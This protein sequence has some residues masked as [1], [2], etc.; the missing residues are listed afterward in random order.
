MAEEYS[1]RRPESQTFSVA[2][3]QTLVMSPPSLADFSLAKQDCCPAEAGAGASIKS[4]FS[5]VLALKACSS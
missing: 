3:R 2:L 1:F 4:T 5:V